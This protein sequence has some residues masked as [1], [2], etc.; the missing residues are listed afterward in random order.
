MLVEDFERII[1]V[2]VYS[3]RF[4]MKNRVET[5]RGEAATERK[6]LE[7]VLKTIVF[8][9][10]LVVR[11]VVRH[12]VNWVGETFYQAAPEIVAITKVYWPIHSLEAS[13]F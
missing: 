1:R 13:F 2:F 5:A 12:I 9:K 10:L 4:F 3:C 8:K 6:L 11:I 7:I